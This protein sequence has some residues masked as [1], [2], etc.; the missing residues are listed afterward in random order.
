MLLLLTLMHFAVDGL[1]GAVLSDLSAAER[2]R[3]L[4]CLAFASYTLVA[5]GGQ[6]LLGWILDRWANLLRISFALSCT[7]LCLG[8]L[9]FPGIPWEVGCIAVGNGLFHVAGGRYVLLHSSR[10]TEPGIFVSSGAIGLALGLN[11]IL[12]IWPFIFLC[13]LLT[14]LILLFLK[15]PHVP[16]L[17]EETEHSNNSLQLWA[18]GLLLILCVL[19]RGFSGNGHLPFA[20]ML[21][22]CVFALG[23]MMGGILC[24]R[25]GFQKTVLWLFLVSAFLLQW[26]GLIPFVFFVL[27]CNMTMPLTLRLLYL[28]SP[29]YPGLMFGLA[30]A[31]LVPGAFLRHIVPMVPQATIVMQFVALSLAWVLYTKTEGQRSH[32]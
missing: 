4:I 5:F 16:S 12:S 3:E 17:P 24:D 13:I 23:K 14:V 19:L 32:E 30:A 1:C 7:L 27:V 10:Y 11:E 31:C 25:F 22:P 26:E 20:V 2:D 9:A 29:R 6:I 8:A 15:T 21:M 18:C 28:T